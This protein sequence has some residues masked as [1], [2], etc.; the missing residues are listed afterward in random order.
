VSKRMAER[1]TS[2][3]VGH[4]PLWRTLESPGS[5]A[6]PEPTLGPPQGPLP[7]Q[8]LQADRWRGAIIGDDDAA[9]F[10]PGIANL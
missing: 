2:D 6:E 5:L 9:G 8:S 10:N 4:R 3:R 7:Q 1:S